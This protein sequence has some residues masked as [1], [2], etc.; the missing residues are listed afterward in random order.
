[1]SEQVKKPRGFQVMSKERQKEIASMGG[2]TAHEMGV[3]HEFTREQAR[4]AGR[5][6]GL[7]RAAKRRAAQALR[8]LNAASQ[9]MGEEL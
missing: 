3:A 9:A 1:M 4:K 7:A 5:K 8:K 2:K 6:G